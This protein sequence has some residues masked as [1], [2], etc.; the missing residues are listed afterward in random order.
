MGVCPENEPDLENRDPNNLNDHVKVRIPKLV[1]CSQLLHDDSI[2][3]RVFQLFCEMLPTPDVLDLH[4]S[5]A[6]LSFI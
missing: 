1:F 3:D 4:F 2:H 5:K 6:K